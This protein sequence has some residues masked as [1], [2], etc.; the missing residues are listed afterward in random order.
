MHES[1]HWF[2][3]GDYCLHSRLPHLLAGAAG[4]S[5][6]HMGAAF[7]S[8][9]WM[10]SAKEDQPRRHLQIRIT[11]LKLWTRRSQP[12]R[13]SARMIRLQHIDVEEESRLRSFCV[14]TRRICIDELLV[15]FWAWTFAEALDFC[16]SL[17]LNYTI[18]VVDSQ[19]P[20]IQAMQMTMIWLRASRS[21]AGSILHQGAQSWTPRN[22]AFYICHFELWN[23]LVIV[24]TVGNPPP[25]PRLLHTY[26]RMP[27]LIHMYYILI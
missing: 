25:P 24:I 20:A 4:T 1:C 8:A 12:S 18:E 7:I 9:G 13:H 10:F 6:E 11:L 26:W 5:K 14:T 19:E 17:D 22:E 15:I 21:F 2:E 3:H 16:R 23:Q 27:P